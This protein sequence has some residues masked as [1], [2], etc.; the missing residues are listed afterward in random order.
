M[1]TLYFDID[2]T[3]LSS[4]QHDV[5]SCLANGRL[6]AAIRKA[7]FRKLVCVGNFCQIAGMLRESGVEYDELAALFSICRGAFCDQIWLRS[8]ASLVTN[9][10]HRT[11]DIDVSGDWW[12]VDDFAA[13]CLRAANQEDLLKTNDGTRIFIPNPTGNGQDVVDWLHKVA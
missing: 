7:G 13:E 2:G 8:V 6:E 12:Y 3:I 11:R 4:D 10:E 5:K 9:P 1:K